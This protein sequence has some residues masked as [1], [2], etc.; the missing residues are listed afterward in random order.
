ML[1]R[2][3]AEHR[4]P[5]E[6]RGVFHRIADALAEGDFGLSRHKI[7]G[8]SAI[9]PSTAK[10]I[11]DN[12]LAYGENLAPLHP[13]TWETSVYR[14]MDGYWQLLVD[15]TTAGMQVS[16]LTLHAKLHDTDR[17]TLEIQSVHVP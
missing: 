14:W 5:P 15:L 1:E 9:D 11:A 7:E 17:P 13:A 8:V 2:D 6:W 16:D 4:I 3:D 12:I 10:S